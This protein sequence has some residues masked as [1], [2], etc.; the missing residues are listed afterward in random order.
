MPRA[1]IRFQALSHISRHG[2]KTDEEG[3]PLFLLNNDSKTA[4]EVN[5][6]HF[7]PKFPIGRVTGNQVP[8]RFRGR[9]TAANFLDEA[10]KNRVKTGI[11]SLFARV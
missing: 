3:S 10:L 1:A 11:I 8:R 6:G 2:D 4:R 7:E 9:K 5:S